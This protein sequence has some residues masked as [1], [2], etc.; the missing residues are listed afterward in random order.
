MVLN[1][2]ALG[3]TGFFYDAFMQQNVTQL[4]SPTVFAPFDI[5][6]LSDIPLVGPLLFQ[7]N[8]VV[9]LTYVL[10]VVVDVALFRTRWGLRTRAI[11]EH[12][13]A[14]DT[15]GI[16]VLA[17]R[18]R[19]VILGGAVAGLAG[20]YFT[21]GS[22]GA[23]GKNITSGNGFIALAAVI[24]G[25]WS[26]RGAVAAALLFGFASALQTLLSITVTSIPS[27]FLGMLPYLATI[28]AVA[29][30]V[31]KVRAPAAD[32]EPY[33]K[34]DGFDWAAAPGAGGR[35]DAAR[36]R[37]VLLLPGGCRRA[38]RG[39]AGGHRL[40]RRERVLRRDPVRRVRPGLRAA[41]RR[42]RTAHALRLRGRRG[43]GDHAVRSVPAAAP[44]ARWSHPGADDRIRRPHHGPGPS[45]RLRG[46]QPSLSWA[47][48]R[49]RSR[50]T[51]GDMTRAIVE[52]FRELHA[53]PEPLLLP[54]PWDVGSARLLAALGYAA[55]ATTS[56]GAALAAGRADGAL[57][58]EATLA[59]AAEIVGATD[60]PVSAD[61]ENGFAD[62][63]GEV[64]AV[65][66]SAVE[67]GLAGC[68][69]EDYDPVSDTIY[70]LGQAV[71][72]ISA[73]V[74]AA[75]DDLVLTARAEN[76]IRGHDDVGDTL[77]RLAAYAEAGAHVLYAPGL[78]SPDSI[79]AAVECSN[80]PL[81]VLASAG[82]PTVA[83]LGRLGVRRVSVG[84]AFAFAAYAAL[85]E[86][87]NEL[88]DRGSY[89]FLG[90]TALG[91]QAA[92]DALG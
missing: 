83:E 16:K 28:F 18:Y 71:E 29:G 68:S 20:A 38:G 2:F 82:V 78:K 88:Q 45:R 6:L 74:D 25:R 65:V 86:A 36:L 46:P 11:G 51:V 58:R 8:V 49:R 75:G 57:G 47:S 87:A 77:T 34:P 72:R 1:V 37:A 52:E 21:I 13:K 62:D 40:Q 10:I 60:L 63:P 55:L 5:P 81:N 53:A 85:A 33:V 26:P 41:P 64:A 61:L 56:S 43:G 19:N 59:H 7:A 17:M 23:F 91:Q 84:G 4:N 9:Y 48:R 73:A 70:P 50:G 67:A 80:R 14:A 42:G 22:V 39:R 76:Q 15:V 89:E 32:G 27:S 30:L 24:F 54:N 35:G 31:G 12:P 3:L 90:R 79:R 66:R 44:G 92:R 69:I